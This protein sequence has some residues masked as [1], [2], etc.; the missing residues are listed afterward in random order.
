MPQP[1]NKKEREHLRKVY[2]EVRG[3]VVDFITHTVTDGT[4]YVSIRFMD[5]TNFC[6]GYAS[7]M[8]VVEVDLSNWKSGDMDMIREYMKPNPK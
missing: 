3:E 8:C 5:G 6:I 2:P 4:L 1:L 7:N